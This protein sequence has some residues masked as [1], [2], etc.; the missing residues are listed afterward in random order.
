MKALKR[1]ISVVLVSFVILPGL[2]AQNRNIQHTIDD[3][4]LDGVAAYNLG[5][6][7]KAHALFGAVTDVNPLNDAAFYY[8]GLCDFYMNDMKAAEAEL[9]EAVSLDPAN[10]WYKDR[11]AVLYSIKGEDEKTVEIYES[12]LK[13]YPK[14]T[15][16]HYSLVN[17]YAKLGR[18]EKLLETLDA[19]ETIQGVSEAT[20]TTRY[21][22]LMHMDRRDDAF[23]ALESY[24]EEF[25]SANIL[26]MMGDA[27]LQDFEDSLALKYYNE[28]LSYEPD[29]APA[30]LGRAD[31]HRMRREY[32]EF[33]RDVRSFMNNADIV[34]AAKGQYLET[35]M[36]HSDPQF[37][38]AHAPQIDSLFDGLAMSA[39][40]D[41][42]VVN[43]AGMYFY[44]SGN[45]EKSK[46]Y[47]RQAWEMNKESISA[48][49]TYIQVLGLTEDW[50]TLFDA[51]GT[52]SEAF[53]D[54]PAFYQYKAMSAYNL[55]RYDDVVASYKAL[56]KQFPKDQEILVESYS[57]IGDVMHMTGNSKEAFK[58]Y[59]K[60]LSINPGYA[61]V[62]NN[63]AYYLSLE[64]RKLKKAYNMS[65]ITVEQEPD[66]ATYLD[67]FGW[68]LYLRGQALEA[69]PFF[70]HA[71]LYGGKDSVTV[72]DH[73][74]E[75]LYVLGEY[76]LAKVYWNQAKQKNNGEIPDLEEKIAKR[77]ESIK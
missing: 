12:L 13:D 23:R 38:S 11:L 8:L 16:I 21:D 4:M 44:R 26:A 71:M 20:V 60:A 9:R 54:E 59:E 73:Y 30:L 42:A 36:N 18:A 19:I 22:V 34:T 55:E 33:F 48:A 67:T 47:F 17:L 31:V 6:Y 14:K 43:L 39:P 35:L 2:Y 63:Y 61:P 46:E 10:Y 77:L 65:K 75:V 68:I 24:N 66:N 45:H 72:L 50:Q 64:G 53:P 3:M 51:A 69:K 40:A 56:Q 74:A 25:A 29:F 76:D 15:D 27:K 41:T 32:P 28:A 7:A 62:L 49:A 37:L 58:A 70:K 5:D 1:F 52:F 57:G